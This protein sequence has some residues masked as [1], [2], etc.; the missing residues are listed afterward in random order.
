[1]FF[2]YQDNTIE[3]FPGQGRLKVRVKVPHFLL[4]VA[5]CVNRPGLSSHT[6]VMTSIMFTG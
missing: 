6:H 3:I 1:M 5:L 4:Q 2:F